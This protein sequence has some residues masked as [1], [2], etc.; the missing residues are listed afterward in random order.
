MICLD[1]VVDHRGDEEHALDFV[2]HLSSSYRLIGQG[3]WCSIYEL[4]CPLSRTMSCWIL[5][6][7]YQPGNAQPCTS[8]PIHSGLLEP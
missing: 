5:D 4:L 1:F 6:T 2:L 3:C 7:G 8:L